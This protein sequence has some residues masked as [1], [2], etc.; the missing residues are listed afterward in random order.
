[1]ANDRSEIVRKLWVLIV[2]VLLCTN[3]L[4]IGNA[5]AINPQEVKYGDTVKLYFDERE[6]ILGADNAQT[7]IFYEYVTDGQTVN[8]WKELVTL[9]MFKGTQNK[10]NAEGFAK[11]Y[12]SMIQNACGN[13]LAI[14]VIR[15]NPSDYMFEWKVND[16]PK[17]DDQYELDRVI[18]GRE[19]IVFIHYTIK[20]NTI[21]P[22]NRAK[23]IEIIDKASLE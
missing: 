3:G 6:W 15:S 8:D 4:I 17:F 21:T 12:L 22:E 2:A 23:W 20:T 10:T 1:M 11:T 5:S 9:Q 7:N 13:E 19:S 14:S 16:H 18:A